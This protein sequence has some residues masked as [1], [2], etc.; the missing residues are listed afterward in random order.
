M[1]PACSGSIRSGGCMYKVYTPV[2]LL[3]SQTALHNVT[4]QIVPTLSRDLVIGLFCCALFEV[5]FIVVYLY[6]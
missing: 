2:S 1:A 5:F 6:T 4:M 3:I